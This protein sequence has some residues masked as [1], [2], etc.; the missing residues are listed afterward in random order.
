MLNLLI[1]GLG[2]FL[3]AILRYGIS[4]LVAARQGPGFPLATLL[5]NVLGCLAIG[6]L[7]ALLEREALTANMRLF[8]AVG[9]LGSFT[10]FSTFGY[11]TIELFRD[12]DYQPALWSV[13][14]NL[15]LGLVAVLLGRSLVQLAT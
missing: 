15:L 10:T 6:A 13:A 1:V 9:L 8:L 5:V 3:G 14:A 11:E 4:S 12:G 2:G 7:M